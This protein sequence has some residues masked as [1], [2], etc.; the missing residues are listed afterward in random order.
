MKKFWMSAVIGSA[1]VIGLPGCGS[2][3]P[4]RN[5][6]KE[7]VSA[8][9]VPVVVSPIT[10]TAKTPQ[11]KPLRAYEVKLANKPEATKGP[12]GGGLQPLGDTSIVLVV[13]DESIVVDIPN[14]RHA[15]VG[16]KK[17]QLNLVTSSPTV[18]VIPVTNPVSGL[19]TLELTVDDAKKM[20]QAG[21]FDVPLTD[22][23]LT[24]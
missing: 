19:R 8:I 7:S 12:D 21:K 3:D 13:G 23:V 2:K 17:A 11:G 15:I 24:F 18:V 6:S 9:E 16:G 20:L 4:D 5:L 1:M 14:A 22:Q 10:T